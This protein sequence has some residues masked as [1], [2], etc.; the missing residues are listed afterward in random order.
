V[1][2]GVV[3]VLCRHA[4]LTDGLAERHGNH[5]TLGD[6]LGIR[7]VADIPKPGNRSRFLDRLG[8]P[9]HLQALRDIFDRLGQGPRRGRA[10]PG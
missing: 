1:L 9:R 4:W 10:R 6:I 7:R 3:S 8:Q 5:P 2:G